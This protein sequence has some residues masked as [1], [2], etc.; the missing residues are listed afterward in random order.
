MIQKRFCIRRAND[1]RDAIEELRM[2]AEITCRHEML[3][4]VFVLNMSYEET[5]MMIKPIKEAFPDVK[6][7]GLSVFAVEPSGIDTEDSDSFAEPELFLNF[8]VF[9]CSEV[10]IHVF[11]LEK[12]TVDELIA[13]ARARIAEQKDLKGI[14]VYV[15]NHSLPTSRILESLT[16]GNEQIPIFGTIAEVFDQGESGRGQFFFSDYAVE[17]GI[18]LIFYTG[19]VLNVKADYIFGWKPVGKRMSVEV[20]DYPENGGDTALTSIDGMKPEEIFKKYFGIGFDRYFIP[21]LREFPFIVE[22]NG[23]FIGRFP[24]YYTDE[25]ELVFAGSI[26]PDEKVQFS[27]ALPG[28]LL[29]NTRTYSVEMKNFAPEAVELYLCENRLGMLEKNAVQEIDYYR[30]FCPELQ[31]CYGGGEIYMYN[32]QGTLLNNS[33]VAVGMRE[34]MQVI[35]EN[36]DPETAPVTEQEGIA[37]LSVRVLKFLQ[38]MTGDLTSSVLEAERANKAKSL[39]LAK[40]SHEL[41]TPI[42]AVLGM[43]EMIL[44]E[45]NE[46]GTRSYANDIMSAGKSLLSLLNDIL[47]FSKVEEGRMEIIPVE[48]ETMSKIN[49][50]ENMVRARADKSGIKFELEVDRNIPRI[51]YGDEIR[52]KQCAMNLLTNAVKYTDSGSVMLKIS[53]L[54]KDNDHVLIE[55]L[56]TDTGIG[57]RPEDMDK[58]FAPFTR[59]EEERN[60]MIEGTGLGISITKQ[61]LALMGSKLEVESTYGQGSQFRFVIEQKVIDWEAIGN[62]SRRYGSAQNIP[63]YH[64]LFTA[65]EA[66][67]LVVDDLDVNLTVLGNLLKRTLVRVDTALSGREALRLAKEKTYDVIFIDHMMPE[68]DGIETYNRLKDYPT[69]KDTVFIALTAN[70]ISGAREMYLKTGFADYLS[71]PVEPENLERLLLHYLP[72]GK[73]MISEEQGNTD[74]KA[75]IGN[76]SDDRPVSSGVIYEQNN[77]GDHSPAGGAGE[78][79]EEHYDWLHDIP[80]IE[81]SEGVANCGTF[82]SFISVITVFHKAAKSNIE[83]IMQCYEEKD[84]KNY[85][86]KVHGLKSAARIIGASELSAA[87]K[88]LEDAGREENIAFIDSHNDRLL[89]MYRELESKLERFD[90]Q[91]EQKPELSG[92]ELDEAFQTMAEIA[93]SMDYGLMD[94]LLGNLGE[95]RIDD[96]DNELIKKIGYSLLKLDWDEIKALLE[97]R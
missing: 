55:F 70:A 21:Q 4:E 18:M 87:A 51:L 54:R 86:I 45:S 43:D 50:L 32:G 93:N 5:E 79:G 12:L 46:E 75:K 19:S 44:R 39:F 38:A 6:T 48:Y 59:I 94:D 53:S 9:S 65:P 92:A 8:K 63:E 28:E 23:A 91:E 69:T 89:E 96:D 7:A 83:E 13:G 29:E 82:D 37:P 95:Y 97:Q 27:Y 58:L 64:E 47:D 68:M 60:R 80:E 42:N 74:S 61:L 33:L 40:M 84:L 11:D 71:K 2:I 73:V 34:G 66:N 56:V 24:C 31:Y 10:K 49:D 90:G 17:S 22:R 36:H 1:V 35:T 81:I 88:E 16:R 15:A 78:S 62:Y 85:T 52:I 77:I 30:S 25:G 67:V 76:V 26:R 41:R 14:E 3:M 57:I 20:G 72:A